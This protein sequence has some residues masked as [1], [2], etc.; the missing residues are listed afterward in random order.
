MGTG[1]LKQKSYP[2]LAYLKKH[3]MVTVGGEAIAFGACC[4]RARRRTGVD[5]AF[6]FLSLACAGALVPPAMTSPKP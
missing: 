1:S 4:R 2:T 3:C 5:A 6:A